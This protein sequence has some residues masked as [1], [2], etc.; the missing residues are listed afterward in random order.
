MPQRSCYRIQNTGCGQDN[1]RKVKQHLKDL[2]S[3]VVR[4]SAYHAPYDYVLNHMVCDFAETVRWWT[5][6][7]EY[8]PEEIS[9]FFF[10]TTTSV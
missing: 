4:E 6:N 2:F 1:R 10:E 8:S 9:A 5:V 7:R 3:A